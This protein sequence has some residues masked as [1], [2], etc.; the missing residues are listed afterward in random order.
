MIS[1][2]TVLP[3]VAVALCACE[4]DGATDFGAM[5]VASGG[6]AGTSGVLPDPNGSSS[7]GA[8][9]SSGI[10]PGTS[11]GTSAPTRCATPPCADGERCESD[12]DCVSFVCA[13]NGTCQAARVGD[14]VRNGD[15]TDVDCGGPGAPPCGVGLL[16]VNGSDCDSFVCG[17]NSRCQPPT[18]NDN[19]QNGDESDLDCGGANAPGCDL[20]KK[21]NIHGDCKSNG[22]VEAGL[23]GAG[24]CADAASCTMQNG[25]TTC[26]AREVGDPN[27][28]HES[29]C[30]SLPTPYVDPFHE[31]KKVYLDK[32]EITAGRMRKFIERMSELYGVPNVRQWV[33]DNLV[34][35]PDLRWNHSGGGDPFATV[36]QERNWTR[37]L[38]SNT[39]GRYNDPNDANWEANWNA[40][41]V[42]MF[43]D[44]RQAYQTL[45]NRNYAAQMAPNNT[46][47]PGTNDG[48]PT[49]SNV[50]THYIFGVGG[51]YFYTHGHNCDSV[52][53]YPTYWYPNDV[54]SY[55]QGAGPRLLSK[56][57][58][59][60][61]ALNCTPPALF[62]A[63]CA[64]DGGELVT[65]KVLAA[66]TNVPHAGRAVPASGAGRGRLAE[67]AANSLVISW[68]SDASES[69]YNN[70][71]MYHVPSDGLDAARIAP[72]GR[73][74]QDK[75]EWD[76]GNVH[77]GPWM[78]LGGNLTEIALLEE[79]AR[80]VN[81]R[82]ALEFAGV[83]YDGIGT[84]SAR[85]GSDKQARWP[86]FKSGRVGARCM[87]FRD[88]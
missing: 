38:P 39:G 16:C 47:A 67:R 41:T 86:D 53:G 25:G 57:D 8:A 74:P 69:P 14:G 80:G 51:F 68:G 33:M 4:Y 52:T 10:G 22:C 27:A 71:H 88:P 18:S 30:T 59:D 21:C 20:G 63:F 45:L 7:S 36:G 65:E 49:Y 23:P 46:P 32:Y 75:V 35:K 61:R 81:W 76:E 43:V 37:W 70:A 85:A 77:Y 64:W 87:R 19:V 48:T 50:G 12:D 26:G 5:D 72:P 13:P 60:R 62:A 40:N 42:T 17:D 54:Q 78:D 28:Q 31:G 1:I 83:H 2:R 66:V 84:A 24:R 15:E 11:S 82:D 9:T 73:M 58:L 44:K 3:M 56:D 55:A 79:S 34:G 6:P 29:C